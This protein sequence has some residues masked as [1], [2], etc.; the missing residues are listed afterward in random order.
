MNR[1][2]KL[3]ILLFC[4]L[5]LTLHLI[6]DYHSGFQGDELLHIETG[7]HLAWGYME[8]PPL[9]GILAFFQNLFHSH[10]VFV[11]HIFPHLAS[12]IILIF[13]AKTTIELGGKNKAVFLVL[14][15]IIIAPGFGR[16]QQLFQPVVFSQLFWVLG[17][18]SMVSFVKHLDKKS[19]WSLTIFCILGFLT[20][21]DAVFFI[22][23]LS[24]LI[25]F[26]RTRIALFQNKFWW[27]IIIAT[28]SIL[29]NLI[30]QVSNDYPALQMFARLY[31]T[32]L[33]EISRF[34][35]LEKL[36]VGINPIVT[37]LL[38]LP[39]IYYLVTSKNKI[40]IFPLAFAIGISFFVLLFKN[41][42][43][44]YFYPI[45]L[46]IIP[47][48]AIFLEQAIMKKKKWSIYPITLLMILGSVFIPFGMPVYAFNRYLSK[49]YPF[50]KRQIEG[51]KYAIR[52]DEYYTN[53]KWKITMQELKSVYDS[54]PIEEKKNC[55]IWGKHY[56][57]AGAINLFQDEYGLP[58][59]FSYHGSFYSWT[60]SGQMPTTIIALSYRVGDFFQPYFKNVKKVRTIYNPYADDEEELY[61]YIYICSE[62]KQDL[63]KMK[64]LF[65]RRIFE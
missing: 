61:Q 49:I 24:A 56:G 6:A 13:V 20:K 63:D 46:T 2:T 52:Y 12:I 7:K 29:P 60:P 40:S 23:G 25:F 35:N 4:I 43:S 48:G 27:N 44:Y 54:L 5:K 30:W 1:Q 37:L 31:E 57:Q 14:L 38:L 47:F 33:N 3:I 10:S 26:R 58:K 42:K 17:F 16:S 28:I 11:H 19:L 39:G 32:Q 21:Y 41:G 22:T 36:L 18:Y 62:P 8:F 15:G 9:I 34:A 65:K 53:N 50:E 55:M 45:I 51:G 64:E 59:S